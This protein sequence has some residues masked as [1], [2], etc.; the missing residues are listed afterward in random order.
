MR[1][2][3]IVLRE[4]VYLVTCAADFAARKHC[5]QTRKGKG[6][7]PY[8]NHLAEVATIL[9]DTT[10][11]PNAR[12]VAAGWLHD[13]VEDTDTTREELEEKFGRHVAGYVAEVTDDKSL[14]KAERKR[15]Q[16]INAPHKSAE[17]RALKIADKISNLRSLMTSPPDDWERARLIDYVDWSEQ[18]V[19]GCRGVNAD[20]DRL[21]DSTVR[22][23]RE[24]I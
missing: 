2:Y 17:A 10:E 18:V 7:E 14:P 9:A 21:F 22:Q 13:T 8:I 19:N 4:H 15:L 16:I 23:A 24:L 20:L 5:G 1:Q 12:L 11:E 3:D 6:R